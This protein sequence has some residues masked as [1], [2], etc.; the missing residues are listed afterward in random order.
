M[1]SKIIAG[2]VLA[3]ALAGTISVHTN[4]KSNEAT[5][6]GKFHGTIETCNE[7][8]IPNLYYQFKSNDNKVW[9]LLTENEMGFVP[10][11]NAEYVLVYDNNGTTETNKPC[12]CA[13]EY[14]CECEVYDDEFISIKELEVQ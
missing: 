6:I 4:S 3:L 9:W 14:E 13:P 1:K 8:E 12:D 11:R 7:N 5:A 10:N 2:A